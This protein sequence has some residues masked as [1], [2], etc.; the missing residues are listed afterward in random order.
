MG[1]ETGKQDTVPGEKSIND[2]LGFCKLNA[3]CEASTFC[4]SDFS[5]S[6]PSICLHGKKLNSDMCDYGF[7]CYS[8]CCVEGACSHF[9]NCIHKCTNNEECAAVD[10]MCCSQGQ[11]TESIVCQGNKGI[12][13]YCAT[14]D[15]C[16]SS[17]CDTQ[18]NI[19]VSKQVLDTQSDMK[20]WVLSICGVILALLIF[21]C[22]R[23]WYI[24]NV[25]RSG[26]SGA[27]YAAGG[28]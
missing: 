26:G 28:R 15:E 1:G 10:L 27:E 16:M 13:D 20:V 4:C 21:V 24:K 18:N 23:R 6:D 5:C 22:M 3:D 9:L 8:R 19:C 17:Y 7:E 14:S 25:G 11:C 2:K 12:G